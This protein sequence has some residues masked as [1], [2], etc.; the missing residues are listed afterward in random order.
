MTPDGVI[1]VTLLR[2]VGWLARLDLV[3][4][5]IPAGPGLEAPGAQ[6][7]DGVVAELTLAPS[8]DDAD[9]RNARAGELG[10]RAVPAG[11]PP[12]LPPETALVTIESPNIELSA[13]KPAEDGNGIVLRVLNPTDVAVP[14][15]IRLGIPVSEVT[16]VRLDETP[17]GDVVEL[18]DDVVRIDVGPHALRTL[19]LGTTGS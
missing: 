10:L 9:G 15:A 3:A 11:D 6:C 16:S 5:P 14:A 19:R 12:I 4:R 17:D 13:L 8:D 18:V 2:A 1:A 7:P